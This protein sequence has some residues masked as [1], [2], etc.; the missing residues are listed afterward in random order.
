MNTTTFLAA[1]SVLAASG[2]A[3]ELTPLDVDSTEQASIDDC[4]GERLLGVILDDLDGATADEHVSVL[5]SSAPSTLTNLRVVD[6]ELVADGGIDGTDSE[7]LVELT[8]TGGDTFEIVA[9]DCD[10]STGLC[11]YDVDLVA[12]SSSHSVCTTTRW[13]RVQ[14]G[15]FTRDGEFHPDASRFAFSCEGESAAAKGMSWGYE[16]W[17]HPEHHQAATRLARAD[18]CGDGVPR[19][20]D[21]TEITIFDIDSINGLPSFDP[22]TNLTPAFEA[23]WRAGDKG[24]AC[25]GKA[26][27]NV[28]PI[29]GPCPGTLPDPRVEQS[30]PNLGEFCEDYGTDDPLTGTTDV[31]GS[32]TA[33]AGDYTAPDVKLFTSSHHLDTGFWRWSDGSDWYSTRQGFYSQHSAMLEEP[34]SGYTTASYEGILLSHLGVLTLG[35][36]AYTIP[37]KSWQHNA[38]NRYATAVTAPTSSAGFTHIVNE[39]YIF[40]FSPGAHNQA[41]DLASG[42]GIDVQPLYLYERTTSVPADQMYVTSTDENPPGSWTF[43][44]TKTP[45][46]YILQAPAAP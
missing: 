20:F 36:S 15:Y 12:G 41:L 44:Y 18:Y 11:R 40:K 42:R 26:R 25:L 17:D 24:A 43:S 31:L 21:G 28:M 22:F 9:I 16:P 27:W 37:L 23:A 14:S 32:L 8:T 1:F 19:T 30:G 33:L 45:L 6:G 29:G 7:L 5:A 13:A 35:L 46:G 4:Q 39:G 38:N 2:C 34:V 10:S 3:L